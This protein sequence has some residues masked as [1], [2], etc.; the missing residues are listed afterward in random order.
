[1]TRRSRPSKPTPRAWRPGSCLPWRWHGPVRSTG[2]RAAATEL[3]ARIEDDNEFRSSSARTPPRWWPDSPRRRRWRQRDDRISKLRQ[4]ADLYEAVADRY[5][6]FYT[7]IN[8]ATLRLLGGDLERA[9]ALA[10]QARH[11]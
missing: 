10:E 11:W 7:C 9:R 5:G 4:A 8:A 6:R 1:M 3:L 2:Q